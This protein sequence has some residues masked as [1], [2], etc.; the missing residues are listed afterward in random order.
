MVDV[1]KFKLS[2]IPQSR[3]KKRQEAYNKDLYEINTLALLPRLINLSELEFLT[4]IPNLLK[5]YLT[6]NDQVYDE[7]AIVYFKYLIFI[8]EKYNYKQFREK[9]KERVNSGA[10]DL[11]IKHPLYREI[12]LTIIIEL[13]K[14]K[15]SFDEF[16]KSGLISQYVDMYDVCNNG[17]HR[18]RIGLLILLCFRLHKNLPDQ[19]VS[20]VEK[21]NDN[22]TSPYIKSDE[23]WGQM[24]LAYGLCDNDFLDA[25][26]RQNLLKRIR[27]I[28][29]E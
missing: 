12:R 29:F 23:F 26:Q 7:L 25:L 15:E 9:T 11:L 8:G 27:R 13:Q 18:I 3:Q 16:I 21:V 17:G 20:V 19:L 4:Y 22:L 1:E 5:F 6:G 24:F 2:S 10:K 14:Q 28:K